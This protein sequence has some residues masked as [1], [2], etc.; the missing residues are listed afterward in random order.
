VAEAVVKYAKRVGDMRIVEFSNVVIV[1]VAVV[2]AWLIVFAAIALR[3]M[4]ATS[5][6]NR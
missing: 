6:K 3:N 5:R 4:A 2:V 1:F